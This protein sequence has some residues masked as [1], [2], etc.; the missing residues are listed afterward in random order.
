MGISFSVMAQQNRVDMMLWDE[1]VGADQAK[2]IVEK[3]DFN[4]DPAI[5]VYK[6]A[7]P[8][9]KAIIMCP[10][11]GY[12]WEATGHEGHDMAQWLNNQGVTYVVLKYRLP[13]GNH[14]IPLSDAEQAIRL[15]REHA[16][17]WGVDPSKVGIMGAFRRW[18]SGVNRR[19][20]L[21]KRG[22]PSRFPDTFLSCDHNGPVIHPCRVKDQPTWGEPLCRSTEQIQQRVAG[23]AR[24]SQ[25]LPNTVIR[26]RYSSGSQQ[27]K[28]LYLISQQQSARSHAYLSQRW[29]WL[30]LQRMVH[31]QRPM[32]IRIGEMAPRRNLTYKG[33]RNNT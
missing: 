24:H 30:R 13:Q 29:S 12:G 2:A 8:N 4:R 33:S 5:T 21:H 3:A 27:H 20:P 11:G 1:N 17:E 23:H 6:A 25:S 14:E 18:T 19:H 9:G 16:E 22:N 31:L 28:L 26:R 15:V 32:E 7:K 10:G